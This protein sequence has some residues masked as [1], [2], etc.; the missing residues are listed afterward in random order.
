MLSVIKVRSSDELR[1]SPAHNDA[2][3]WSRA[4]NEVTAFEAHKT[5]LDTRQRK[6]APLA[7]RIVCGVAAKPD[8]A[9]GSQPDQSVPPPGDL[10]DQVRIPEHPVACSSD[11]RSVIPRYPVTPR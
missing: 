5:A 6:G 9:A 2:P 3:A 7:L 1:Q 10:L 8:E 11:I 4:G